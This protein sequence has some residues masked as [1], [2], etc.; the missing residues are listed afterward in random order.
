MPEQRPHP[1]KRIFDY[2]L[3]AAFLAFLL[4]PVIKMA[5][6]PATLWSDSERRR[7]APWPERP[8]T[9]TGSTEFFRGI[10][11][12]LGD[13]FGFRDH[14]IHRY[15]RELQKHFDRPSIRDKVISG[16]DGWLFLNNFGLIDDFLGFSAIP[17]T[18]LGLWLKTMDQR[19][20]TLAELGILYIYLPIPN[21]QS[22]YPQYLMKGA[23][24][25]KGASRYELLLSEVDGQ[26]PSYMVDLRSIFTAYPEEKR[27]YF[28][29]DSHWNRRGAYLAFREIIARLRKNF[30]ENEFDEA[31]TFAPDK[32]GVAGNLGMGGD[33]ARLLQ[34]DDLMETYPEIVPF[35]RC[36]QPQ[37]RMPYT[38]S[39][40]QQTRGRNSFT[41][42]CR[43]KDLRALIF[44]DSYFVQLE[45][46][47]SQNFKEVV[48][49]WKDFDMENVKEL[50]AS[51][52][53]DVVIEAIAERHMFDAI[54]G[55]KNP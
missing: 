11:A 15:H 23:L 34:Q 1:S 12:Y 29:H 19:A 45:P 30:P 33:L 24:A 52:K 32:T 17:R 49:L 10:D 48:Y 51:Y 37:I 18:Q 31:F 54:L 3:I 7:L 39:N 4:A 16:L 13:H 20:E 41:R 21:K 8:T 27:L 9:L 44:R 47:I 50:M 2:L 14:F 6:E 42:N 36:E 26:L 38:F 40:L 43:T 35:N 46:F 25:L 53:P 55:K 28:K 5:I 22:I